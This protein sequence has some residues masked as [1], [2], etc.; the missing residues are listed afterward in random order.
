MKAKNVL[1]RN[2]QGD[3]VESTVDCVSRDEVVQALN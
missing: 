2:L 3:T 1:D